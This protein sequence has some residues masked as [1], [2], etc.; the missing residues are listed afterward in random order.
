MA[1]ATIGSSCACVTLALA[2]GVAVATVAASRLCGD[3][4]RKR[5]SLVFRVKSLKLADPP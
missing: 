2:G 4:S 3:V 1:A 5:E